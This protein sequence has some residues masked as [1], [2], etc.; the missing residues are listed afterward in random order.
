[1]IEVVVEEQVA[2]GGLLR[3]T[4][5]PRFRLTIMSRLSLVLD[6]VVE[7]TLE[8]LEALGFL[9]WLC[10]VNKGMELLFLPAMTELTALKFFTAFLITCDKGTALPIDAE[11][12]TVSEKIGLASEV[13][14]VVSIDAL[15]LVM[16]MIVRAPLR[17]EEE[18]VEVIVSL[19]RN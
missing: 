12:C 4:E 19:G 6:R 8:A 13:L 5:V 11:V 3:A 16:L 1:V 7:R 14:E 17:F 18:H 10:L 9:A 15:S 2:H